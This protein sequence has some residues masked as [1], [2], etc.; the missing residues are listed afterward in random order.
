MRHELSQFK[1]EVATL[2]RVSAFG[3]IEMTLVNFAAAK[4]R[5][6]V[7]GSSPFYSEFQGYKFHVAIAANGLNDARNTHVS[8][9]IHLMR[10]SFDSWLR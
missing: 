7:W 8:V 5:N 1:K 9:A 10:G 2:T 3:P 4:R 6:A